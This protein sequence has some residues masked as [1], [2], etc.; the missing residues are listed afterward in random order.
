MMY[1]ELNNSFNKIGKPR[2]GSVE[3]TPGAREAPLGAVHRGSP[4][5]QGGSLGARKIPPGICNLT[6]GLPM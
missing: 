6:L 5:S 3:A 1:I 4:W 2:C